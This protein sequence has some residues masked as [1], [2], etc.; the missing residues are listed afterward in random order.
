MPRLRAVDFGLEYDVESALAR[1]LIILLGAVSIK[2]QR[3]DE[4]MT[5]HQIKGQMSHK[6]NANKAINDEEEVKS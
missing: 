5:D 6:G 1:L 2:G 4:S 3:N